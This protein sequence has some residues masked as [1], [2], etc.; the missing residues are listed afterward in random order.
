MHNLLTQLTQI[1][2][3]SG[4]VTGSAVAERIGTYWH[5]QP[6]QALAILRPA[7]TEQLCACL[8]LCHQAG[9]VVIDLIELVQL[10]LCAPHKNKKHLARTV[11]SLCYCA[12]TLCACL[13]V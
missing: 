13:F 2:G 11:Y 1:L 9:Q 7:N 6:M 10:R 12:V 4:I 3:T 8:K 5:P